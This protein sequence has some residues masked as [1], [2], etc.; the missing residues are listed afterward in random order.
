MTD[1]DKAD[2]AACF[3]GNCGDFEDVR[4]PTVLR[5]AKKE[6]EAQLVSSMTV[7]QSRYAGQPCPV[8]EVIGGID[9]EFIVAADIPPMF[10]PD[11]Y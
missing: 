1:L 6:F 9:F 4:Q 8:C 2:S 7:L 3:C 10:V 5:Q 11:Y